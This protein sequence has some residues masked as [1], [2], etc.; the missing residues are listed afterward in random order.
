MP[1][2]AQ[3]SPRLGS[4]RTRLDQILDQVKP[5]KREVTIDADGYTPHQVEQ[6]I[7]VAKS[8]GLHVSGTRRWL[9]IRDLRG[10]GMKKNARARGRYGFE[11]AGSCGFAVQTYDQSLIEENARDKFTSRGEYAADRP[12]LLADKL[13]RGDGQITDRGW[14]QLN[15]DVQ[16]LE[17]NAL[18]W[19]Q[20][21]FINARDEGHDKH[22]DLI[23]TLWFDPDDA[24]QMELIEL[25]EIERIDMTDGSFGNLVDDVWMGVSDFGVCVLGGS[26]SFYDIEREE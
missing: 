11:N 20:K 9:L 23:G 25:G 26:I 18:R 15:K 14:E 5:G 12:I 4:S 21:R 7:A 1:R 16:R 13:I 10:S 3:R 8:R 24:D 2:R 6:I 22:D 17:I 19:L